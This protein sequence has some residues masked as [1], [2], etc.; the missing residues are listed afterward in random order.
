MQDDPIRAGTV[1]RLKSGGPPMT[2]NRNDE[3]LWEC[4]WFAGDEL[5]SAACA[6]EALEPY[7]GPK[8]AKPVI[9]PYP[10]HE[11]HEPPV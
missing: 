5:R 9:S 4:L 1:V 6:A 10:S 7:P 11:A 8:G 2:A 3:G